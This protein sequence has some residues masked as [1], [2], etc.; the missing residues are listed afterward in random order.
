[1]HGTPTHGG[2]IPSNPYKI[3]GIKDNLFP[4]TTIKHVRLANAHSLDLMATQ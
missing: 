3:G 4:L 2:Y 1:M